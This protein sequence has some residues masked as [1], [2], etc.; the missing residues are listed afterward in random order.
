MPA[1][2]ISF[3]KFV[4]VRAAG[5]CNCTWIRWSKT[6]FANCVALLLFCSLL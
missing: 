2:L 6:H 5:R 3:M 1:Y 4:S